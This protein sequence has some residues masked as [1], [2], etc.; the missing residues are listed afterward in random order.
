MHRLA[1]ADELGHED[2]EVLIDP[3]APPTLVPSARLLRCATRW[4]S[5]S[6][7]GCTTSTRTLCI[8]PS[9]VASSRTEAGW[10]NAKPG[11]LKVKPR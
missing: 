10:K 8:P 1:L 5:T 11:C 3:D 9:P 7:I 2:W 4:A 6:A